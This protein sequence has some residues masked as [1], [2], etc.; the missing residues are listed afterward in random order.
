MLS[1][2]A[3]LDIFDFYRLDAMEQSP[4]KWHHLAHVCR[5]WRH[6]ISV[7]P[8]RLELRILCK[9]GAPIESILASWPT[10][11]LVARYNASQKPEL[12]PGNVM[13]T[14][15]HPDRPN[16]NTKSEFISG[17]IDTTLLYPD[18]YH[19]ASRESE[20]IPESVM[21]SLARPNRYNAS[22]KFIPGNVMT[23]LLRP[24]RLCEIDLQV[25]S[26]MTGSIVKVI[27][28]PCQTL[29]SIR[30]RVQNLTGP[31]IVVHSA[32]LGG[33]APHLRN[34]Q[35][36]GISFPFP[37]M[38][39]VL[40]SA[41]NLVELHLLNIPNDVYFSP[42]D[43]ITSL[44]TLVHLKQ[45]KV[46]FHSP[47]SS[48]PPSMR[49]S[50]LQRTTLPSLTLFDFHGASGYLNE[51]VA[52]ID[53]PALCKISIW[54]FNDIIFEIPQYCQ[55]IPSLVALGLPA[56]VFVTHSV[57]HV[58]VSFREGEGREENCFLATSCRQLDW[59][60]SFATQILRQFSP[61]L[62]SVRILV[63]QRDHEL[64][65][66]EEDVDSTQ[67]LELFQLFTHVTEVHVWDK[68]LVPGIMKALVA[69][70][71]APGILPELTL[72]DLVGYREF[73]S[74]VKDVGKFIRLS[75][76]RVRYTD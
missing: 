75:G 27:Q 52:Q 69:E 46:D 21:T 60:L 24:D 33:S 12:T 73:P 7:S 22:S 13:T 70:D 17:N 28:K 56:W 40:L 36:D 76:D 18:R 38:R 43:L 68:Q 32:F 64:P 29:E 71:M 61:F 2:D 54:L 31:S 42:A 59:Q 10:L 48:P 3:L 37:E 35:L 62:S 41:R 50:P 19:S 23:A 53:L 14:L 15:P 63:I 72:L 16:A 67:W 55:F 1:E 39:R 44:S 65:S 51:F 30:I 47:A 9:S 57:E 26:R 11:P 8:R 25:T 5:K 34:I 49:R 58:Y 6:V 20:Y 66:G 4:W 45:L 74:V